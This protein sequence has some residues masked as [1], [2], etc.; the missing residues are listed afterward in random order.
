MKA[1]VPPN[2][3]WELREWLLNAEKWMGRP[4]RDEERLLVLLAWS[5]WQKTQRFIDSLEPKE[6]RRDGE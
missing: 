1:Q 5:D 4:I 6:A 3:L 2:A